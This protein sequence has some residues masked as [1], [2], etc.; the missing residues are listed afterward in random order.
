MDNPRLAN[1]QDKIDA[2]LPCEII[3]CLSLE[4]LANESKSLCRIEPCSAT[5]RLPKIQCWTI[6]QGLHW[7]L[8]TIAINYGVLCSRIQED[9]PQ[10]QASAEQ[11]MSR[12]AQRS[13]SRTQEA[14]FPPFSC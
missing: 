7:L 9:S 12:K 1:K 14:R 2:L 13:R 6:V 11:E 8:H 10:R 4:K 3:E 5:K